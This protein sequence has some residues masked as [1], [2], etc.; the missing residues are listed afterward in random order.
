MKASMLV[1]FALTIGPNITLADEP[2]RQNDVPVRGMSMGLNHKF[3]L[4]FEKAK[5]EQHGLTGV[6]II[7]D[8]KTLPLLEPNGKAVEDFKLIAKSANGVSTVTELVFEATKARSNTFDLIPV[9]EKGREEKAI[10][11]LNILVKE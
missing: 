8:G 3:T 11:R 2:K 7:M 5:V 6:K 10:A 1:I 4:S 9:Y